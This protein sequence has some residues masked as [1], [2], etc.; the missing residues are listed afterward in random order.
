QYSKVTDFNALAFLESARA[1]QLRNYYYVNITGSYEPVKGLKLKG[2]VAPLN[3][4]L[5]QKSNRDKVDFFDYYGNPISGNAARWGI[6]SNEDRR[7]GRFEL[8]LQGLAEY[9][10]TMNNH[11]VKVL[12]G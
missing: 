5:R 3:E 11:F 4:T 8:Y 7:E 2:T 1:T 6:I 10:K 12:L 9:E